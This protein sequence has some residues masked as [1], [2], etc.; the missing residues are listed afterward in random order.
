VKKHKKQKALQMKI[1]HGIFSATLCLACNFI[2]FG[3]A[4][5]YPQTVY[6]TDEFEITMRTGASIENKIIAMLSSGT[7]LQVI[8]EK[9]DWILVKSPT[10]K[11]GWILKRYASVETPKNIIIEQIEKKYEKASKNLE[12]EREKALTFEKENKELRSAL[13]SSQGKLE[14]INKDYTN[15][16]NESKDYLKLKKEHTSNLD[17]LRKATSELTQLRKENKDLRLSKNVIWFLSGAGVMF[18]SW[19]IGYMMGKIRRRSR[20]YSL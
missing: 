1:I 15:L 4:F 13:N 8:E 2:L 12:I 6:V 19:L 16:M 10:E 14:K 9:D 17:N 5:S 18:T 3:I 20:K 7:E 11:K